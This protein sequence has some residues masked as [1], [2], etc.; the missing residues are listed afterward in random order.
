MDKANMDIT[1]VHPLI[2]EYGAVFKISGKTWS[3][4]SNY[5]EPAM[6]SI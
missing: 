5:G 2:L 3:G 1:I 4:N 6:T